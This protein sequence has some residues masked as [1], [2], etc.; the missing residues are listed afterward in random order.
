MMENERYEKETASVLEK[1]VDF[2]QLGNLEKYSE[3]YMVDVMMAS[4][5]EI[6]RLADK[7]A[8][9]GDKF[10]SIFSD[11][12][13]FENRTNYQND[14][15]TAFMHDMLFPNKIESLASEAKQEIDYPNKFSDI[16]QRIKETIENFDPTTVDQAM[17]QKKPVKNEQCTCGHYAILH[18]ELT[19]KCTA[20]FYIQGKAKPCTCKQFEKHDGESW[21]CK[22]CELIFNTRDELMDHQ[23]KHGN[24]DGQLPRPEGRGLL[25]EKVKD[26]KT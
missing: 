10:K 21:P 19:G 18:D 20:N 6:D 13:Y 24:D 2:I 1:I 7:F 15:F 23:F 12:G 26:R 25:A 22:K 14:L 16:E 3:A 17:E 8:D 4:K 5:N 11:L 9:I